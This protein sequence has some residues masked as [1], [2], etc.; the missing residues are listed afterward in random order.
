[1]VIDLHCHSLK[2]DGKL[3]PTDLVDRAH[4]MGVN[5]LALTDHD[6]LNGLSEAKQQAQKHNIKIING[7]EFSCVWNGMGI[8]IVG[9]GFDH[10]H[11]VMVDAVA[12]Q[13]TRRQERAVTIAAR[14]EKKGA[15]GIWEKT[16]EISNGAQIGRPHFAQALIELGKVSNMGQAFKKYLGAGKPGDVK[17]QWPQLNEVV[18]WIV[19]SGGTAVIAHPDSYKLTRTKLKLL[20]EAFM[21]AGG[22]AMEATTATME[23][24]YRTRM[25]ELCIEYG[26]MAS[27][28]SDFHGPTPWCELGRFNPLPETVKPVWAQWV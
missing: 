24:S 10:E 4:E 14:L 28:G 17:A 19:Q 21:A 6:T 1:M 2:S 9:L 27:Q 7:I 5:V 22:T 12:L 18:E 26:L 20:I 3:S 15:A 16:L 25:N 23:S 8:H 11:P 13:E